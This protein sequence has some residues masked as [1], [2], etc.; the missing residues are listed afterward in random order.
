MGQKICLTAGDGFQ[1]GGY[2]ADP[3]GTPRGAI[4]VIQEIFG[5]NAHIRDVCDRLAEKG[6][7]AV[8]PALFD[9]IKPGFESGYT[10]SEIAAARQLIATPDWPSMLLDTQAA[11]GSL[12]ACGPVG[13]V[14][15]CLGGGIA[16]L[17]ATRLSG[18]KAA[19]GYYGGAIASFADEVPRVPVQLHYGELDPHIPMSNVDV[20][21]SKRPDVAVN[22]YPGANHG[23]NCDQ[24]ASYDA[25]SADL[26]WSRSLAFMNEHLRP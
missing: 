15:F 3:H 18:I 2:R 16:F 20:V 4:V 13:I 12:R 10:A 23:F 5:V 17:A 25:P 22:I 7:A 11:I 6:F 14:G 9:R 24:R 21:R 1:V 8:A 19:V 26:A